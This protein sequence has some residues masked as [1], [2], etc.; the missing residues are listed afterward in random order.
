MK[1]KSRRGFWGL[2]GGEGCVWE[3]AAMKK[4]ERTVY[5]SLLRILLS[6]KS[7]EKQSHREFD[8]TLRSKCG[9]GWG[10]DWQTFN[11]A[12]G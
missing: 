2:G 9:E 1:K 6:Q 5:G 10:G 3:E 11:H 12:R 7:G 4:A 8:V